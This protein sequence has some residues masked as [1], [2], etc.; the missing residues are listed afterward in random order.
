V[1]DCTE[2]WIPVPALQPAAA[3]H[4][5]VPFPE[6]VNPLPTAVQPETVAPDGE[7]AVTAMVPF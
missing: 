7:L 6:Q 1:L 2:T 5:A 4:V 3:L